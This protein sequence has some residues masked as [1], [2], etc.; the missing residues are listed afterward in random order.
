MSEFIQVGVTALR[1]PVTKEF[2]PAVPLYIEKTVEAAESEQ[3]LIKD[4]GKLFA[5]KMQQYIEGGSLTGDVSEEQQLN[6][7]E[8]GR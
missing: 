7:A 3:K 8:E 2:L 1:D 6:S 4:L 5:G